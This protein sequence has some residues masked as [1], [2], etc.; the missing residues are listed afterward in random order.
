MRYLNNCRRLVVIGSHFAG[1]ILGISPAALFSNLNEM[2]HAI[3]TSDLRQLRKLHEEIIGG[4]KNTVAKCIKA[5]EM[6]TKIKSKTKH[7]DWETVLQS[8][9][10]SR[11]TADRYMELWE[12]RSAI[13]MNAVKS[14]SDALK[15]LDCK[16]V[17]VSGSN[18]DVQSSSLDESTAQ[19]EPL[20]KKNR[21]KSKVS[22]TT[23]TARQP[24]T[25]DT[26]NS[27]FYITNGKPESE[28]EKEI[29]L[30]KVGR[31][32][33]EGIL[34]DWD[35]AHEIGTKLRS[36]V[37]EVKCTL[38]N[39]LEG[40]TESDKDIVFR[41][42][43]NSVISEAE[44][45]HYSLSQ[46]VP[47]AVCPSCQGKTNRTCQL[48]RQRGFVSRFYWESPTVGNDLRNVIRKQYANSQ[49]ISA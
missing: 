42:L 37:S 44:A 36:M 32:I 39:G 31:P 22:K 48:C 43:G 17:G 27:R 18:H 20:T 41:E 11:N 46:I 5:G 33:P 12:R 30:D 15:L 10:I 35:R 14:L 3:E 49:A 24:V 26:D 28:P 38:Q 47:Y 34:A 7:G 16:S 9:Q 13:D 21:S 8:V 4:V 6:L 1:H 2:K 45:L 19:N 29:R 25:A 40:R 23:E